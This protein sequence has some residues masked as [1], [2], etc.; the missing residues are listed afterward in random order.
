MRRAKWFLM[1]A[2]TGLTVVWSL[3]LA[4]A[5][6]AKAGFKYVGAKACKM[7]HNTAAQGKQY[8][9]WMASKHSKAY[10]SLASPKALEVAKAKG[11]ADPQK[12]AK[13]VKCHVTGHNAAKELLAP[14]YSMEEGITC[15]GCHGPGESYKDMK[16]MK[17]KKLAMT[18][19]LIMPTEKTCTGCHN[20]ESPTYKEFK[21]TE[22][23]KL[24]AHPKPKPQG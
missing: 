21:F 2:L 11:I 23:A 6:A 13:C 24:I 18:N 5:P 9:I 4:Q 16:V 22:A 8:D 3:T 7:C 12:D 19:G 10:A 14:T 17:D 20:P 15:E 1:V